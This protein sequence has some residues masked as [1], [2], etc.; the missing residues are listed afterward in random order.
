MPMGRG[1]GEGVTSTCELGDILFPVWYVTAR[2]G[3]QDGRGV[4]GRKTKTGE[5]VK[6]EK[7][8]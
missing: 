8:P 6:A 1:R 7:T 4:R 5:E 3:K 2:V